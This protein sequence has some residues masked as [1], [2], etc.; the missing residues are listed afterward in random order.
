M[1]RRLPVIAALFALLVGAVPATAQARQRAPHLK[2]VR[3][4]PGRG[5]QC[6]GGAAIGAQLQLT[7][8]RLYRGMRVS[9]RWSRGAIATKL[10][11]RGRRLVVRVPNGTGGG[12][13]KVRVQGHH[14]FSNY[15]GIRVAVTTKKVNVPTQLGL[16]AVFSGNGMW[17]WQLAKSSGG[18]PAAIAV[19]AHEAGVQT[20]FVKSAD[21]TIVWPQ[22]SVALV[23][24]LH[25]QGLRVCAWQ[26]VY[27]ADAL[28]EAGAAEAAA[29]AGADCIVIDAET[30][31]EGRYGAAQQYMEALRG[32]LGPSYPLGLTSFPY[33]DFHPGLPY[34]VFLAPGAAQANL[35]QVYWKAIGGGVDA[36]SAHTYAHNRVYGAPIVPLGQA[37]D[38]PAPADVAR[39]RQLWGSYGSAGLSWW[40]W[41]S[42]SVATWSAIAAPAPGPVPLTDPGWPA[43]DKGAK[44]DEVVWL[45]QHLASAYP[46]LAVD[47]DFG[48]AT[49]IALQSFQASRGLPVSGV[50]DPATWQAV[51]TLPLHPVA[52]TS[53]RRPAS[54]ATHAH[55]AWAEMTPRGRGR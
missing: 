28:G 45:Q 19:Q 22:F 34:S 21:G 16:P 51:L 33:V 20:V 52:W 3:C 46:T 42:A 4:L 15:V 12:R 23:Q 9:F 40:S 5:S 18:D 41:Q 54:A 8:Q 47:G 39:F 14:R 44:G 17:I 10:G 55:A 1:S 38:D 6:R 43:L 32:A 31:Y 25:A 50:T 13:V 26:Y 24:A 36:V 27:G 49:Q 53:A 48:S 11:K 7:G 35:P 37:Y 29:A 2:Q 30:E